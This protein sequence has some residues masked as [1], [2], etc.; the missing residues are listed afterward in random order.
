MLTVR[1]ASKH[2]ISIT[3]QGYLRTY[4]PSNLRTLQ[5]SST[6]AR[7][8]QDNLG[9]DHSKIYTFVAVN[10]GRP[11]PIQRPGKRQLPRR[12]TEDLPPSSKRCHIQVESDDD[13]SNSAF[14]PFMADHDTTSIAVSL[15]LVGAKESF[16]L[17][18]EF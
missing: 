10:M 13:D 5:F 3:F 12:A 7:Q 11:R 17:L 1:A 8:R 16:S 2:N 15:G 18:I 4:V 6:T 14:G 9:T